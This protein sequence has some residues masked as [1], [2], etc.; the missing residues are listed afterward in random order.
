[1][2][3]YHIER[4]WNLSYKDWKKKI[5]E[6]YNNVTLIQSTGNGMYIVIAD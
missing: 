2:K 3:I 4:D 5:M 6:T 1:M